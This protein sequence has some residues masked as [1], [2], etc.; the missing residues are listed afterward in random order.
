MN[1]I[2]LFFLS[3]FFASC[4]ASH[5]DVIRSLQR[6]VRISVLNEEPVRSSS[7][8]VHTQVERAQQDKNLNEFISAAVKHDEQ[9]GIFEDVEHLM[10]GCSSYRDSRAL[11]SLLESNL[12]ASSE[13]HAVH[14]STRNNLA[15]FSFM[16]SKGSSMHTSLL[17]AGKS[18]TVVSIPTAIKLDESVERLSWDI[19]SNREL[20]SSFT[21]EIG[22]GLGARGKGCTNASRRSIAQDIL[23]TA[24]RTF[25]DRDALDS[26][27]NRFFYTSNRAS[28]HPHVTEIRRSRFRGVSI[29]DRCEFSRLTVDESTSAISLTG[30]KLNAACWRFLA[31]IASI[32]PQVN[33]VS[34][35]LGVKFAAPAETSSSPWDS[36]GNSPTDQNAWMQSGNSVDTPYSDLGIA[37]DGYVLG[38]I[39]SG[40]DDLSCFLVDW[41]GTPTT[42]T[43][44]S[45]VSNPITESSRRKVIQYVAWG[46]GEPSIIYDHGTW[47]SGASIGRCI[48]TTSGANVYNGIAHA[49]QITMFDVDSG[50]NYSVPALYDIALP[51]A[52]KAGARIHSNSWGTVG[53]NSYTSRS[54]DVDEFMYDHPDFLFVSAAA[55]EG[56]DGY[57]SVPAPGISKSA[58]TVGATAVNHNELVHF[59]SVGAAY[60]GAIKPN[61]VA[62][63]ENL[64]SAGVGNTP[65]SPSCNVQKSSGTSMATPIVAGTAL[66][67]KQYMENSSFWGSFCN[68]TYS[69][70][71]SV[72]G[73]DQISGFLVKALMVHSGEP[74][75]KKGASDK[76]VIP[77]MNLTGTPPDIFQGWGQVLLKNV[78][79][80]PGLYE[81]DLFVDDYA[82]LGSL[83]Q[84]TYSVMVEKGTTPLR[85]TIVW[86]DPSN[87]VWAAKNLLNDLDLMVTSPDGT[88]QYGNNI[89]GDELNPLERVVID[90]PVVGKYIITVT[91]KELTTVSQ[92]YAIVIT[93]AGYVSPR[94]TDSAVAQNSI[95]YEEPRQTCEDSGSQ[96]ISFQLED[97]KS[98]SSWANMSLVISSGASMISNCTF[99]SNEDLSTIYY[100]RIFQCAFCLPIQNYNVSIAPFSL[101]AGVNVRVASPQCNIYL[102]SLQQ[103]ASMELRNDGSCNKCSSGEELITVLMLAN[104][105][106]DDFEQYSWQGLASWTISRSDGK[107]IVKA[108]T[109][110]VSDMEAEQHCLSYGTYQFSLEDSAFFQKTRMHA[111]VVITGGG[112]NVDL[113]GT[114]SVIGSVTS[115]GSDSSDNGLSSG[116]IG[117]IFI[118]IVAFIC[119]ATAVYGFYG[120]GWF[121]SK[122]A[123]A[124]LL[125][126]SSA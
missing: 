44:K 10:L 94:I 87:V 108:G 67:A 95:L 109:L 33:F 104:V 32:H 38:M 12:R 116:A 22:L 16:S 1:A 103:T 39:D 41:S 123:S 25:R 88:V 92:T 122:P 118:G 19:E 112:L 14:Y 59:S 63:G 56:D 11:R 106:S 114:S 35:N 97:W 47:C 71:P 58:L 100:N 42:R 8:K 78:L 73:G 102:S 50:T 69:S 26:H 40:V 24:E 27:W 80:I 115:T 45:Q 86:S 37:G 93:S 6:A 52:Y 34:A 4:G 117:G 113:L 90:S 17:Q 31:S 29:S 55:N 49:A 91:A 96:Y 18:Y 124:P 54:L 2:G 84:R 107:G 64:F 3:L 105:T 51:P 9:L 70:C 126:G 89:Q 66:L 110:L 121:Q 28:L 74:I 5:L 125:G 23:R 82:S 79:P 101:P 75:T 43:P 99:I 62:P 15:C 119:L 111:Q 60:D 57:Y 61:V 30:S 83:T 48:N 53:I 36:T 7:P 98:G 13:F 76:S 85:V 77:V 81:F 20:A 72:N 46:D 21:L 120:R 68:T 65:G